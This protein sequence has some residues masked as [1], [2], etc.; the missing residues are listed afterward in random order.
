MLRAILYKAP[1]LS[2]ICPKVNFISSSWITTDPVVHLQMNWI[3]EEKEAS[4]N[5][6]E[7]DAR[8]HP[9]QLPLEQH[10]AHPTGPRPHDRPKTCWR[11]QLT[12]GLG[13]SKNPPGG[14]ELAIEKSGLTFSTPTR[15]NKSNM[16]DWDLLQM[17]EMTVNYNNPILTSQN[18]R[19]LLS[20][21]T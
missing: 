8:I 13:T 3:P 18:S 6:Q 4:V 1:E 21:S 11:D 16:N 12:V 19:I 20:S 5:S 9:G 17:Y 2:Q 10:Q 14:V 15:K 7:S